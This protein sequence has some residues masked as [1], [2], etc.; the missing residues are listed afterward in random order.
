MSSSSSRHGRVAGDVAAVA[1]PAFSPRRGPR[2]ITRHAVGLGTRIVA[3]Q[4]CTARQYYGTGSGGVI[5]RSSFRGGCGG[6]GRGRGR[7]GV[8]ERVASTEERDGSFVRARREG[9]AR[10]DTGR[11]IRRTR[12]RGG[13][14]HGEH[15]AGPQR[16]DWHALRRG[17]DCVLSSSEIRTAE[18]AP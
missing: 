6:R 3:G 10:G 16:G 12:R 4:A 7:G 8:G 17:W 9:G 15:E 5:G 2:R 1:S 18:N 13:V 14:Q 11:G